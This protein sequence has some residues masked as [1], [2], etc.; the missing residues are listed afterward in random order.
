MTGLHAV[1]SYGLHS[2]G[3]KKCR[4]DCYWTRRENV[5]TFPPWEEILV[6]WYTDISNKCIFLSIPIKKTTADTIAIALLQRRS[7]ILPDGQKPKLIAQAYDRAAVMRGTLVG[8][9][10]KITDFFRNYHY[11]H[12]YV[13]QLNFI[14]QQVT[15]HIPRVSISFQTLVDFLYR[16]SKQTTVLDPVV[17]HRLPRA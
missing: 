16:S 1:N 8:V 4:F 9:Q 13:H 7:S 11:V 5:E 10:H 17:A 14:I 15:S 3:S 2:G 12:C 6:L